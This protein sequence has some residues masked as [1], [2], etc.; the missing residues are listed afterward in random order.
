MNIKKAVLTRS[1]ALLFLLFLLFPACA[2]AQTTFDV[3]Y[4][5]QGHGTLWEDELLGNNSSITIGT[6]GCA[7]TCISMVTSYYSENPLTPSDMNRWLKKNNGFED[8]WEGMG[9]VVLNWPALA[10]FKQGYVYTRFD[11]KALPADILLIRYYLDQNVPVIAEVLHRNAPHY[12]VLTGYEGDDFFM[13]DPEFPEEKRLGS[14]Y[15][16]SDKW[17]SGPSRNIYGIR[18]LYPVP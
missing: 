15:N 6:H 5:Q 9:Q 18:V 2:T 11:W 8:D 13:N 7:L 14:V 16:I 10:S 3:P 1:A 12:V 17:G 4:Y